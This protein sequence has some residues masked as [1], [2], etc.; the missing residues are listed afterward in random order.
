MHT[1][2]ECQFACIR[3]H[4]WPYLS[5]LRKASYQVEQLLVLVRGNEIDAR[6]DGRLPALANRGG[7]T[8]VVVLVPAE[9]LAR[10][11]AIERVEAYPISQLVGARDESAQ[12]RV[13]R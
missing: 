2:K 6:P 9:V 3:V 4:W 12:T 10:R 1:N 11:E 7:G 13:V 8:E 5:V